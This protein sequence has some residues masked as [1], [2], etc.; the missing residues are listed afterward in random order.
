MVERASDE[1]SNLDIF[2]MTLETSEP[3]KEL[4]RGKID[5]AEKS[6]L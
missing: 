2:E 5:L 4:V 6:C 3:S 1:K